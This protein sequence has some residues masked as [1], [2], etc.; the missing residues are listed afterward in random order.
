MGRNESCANRDELAEAEV[1]AVAEGDG[2]GDGF[3]KFD[4]PSSAYLSMVG[5]TC[6]RLFYSPMLKEFHAP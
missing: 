5:A 1:A 3:W 6:P 2:A 4:P